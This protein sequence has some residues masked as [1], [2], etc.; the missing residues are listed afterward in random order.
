[1]WS[2]FRPDAGTRPPHAR[3]QPAGERQTER[4]PVGLIASTHARAVEQSATPMGERF[5]AYSTRSETTIHLNGNLLAQVGLVLMVPEFFPFLFHQGVCRDVHRTAGA[6]G[7]REMK[8]VLW[9]KR[10]RHG[11]GYRVLKELDRMEQGRNR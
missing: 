3:H 10:V 7:L 2:R 1:M 9:E 6:D 5:D 8:D 4:M 11:A